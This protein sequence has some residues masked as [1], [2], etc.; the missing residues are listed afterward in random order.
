[1]DN[2]DNGQSAGE[3]HN[4][5]STSERAMSFFN[6]IQIL[7]MLSMTHTVTITGLAQCGHYI[8]ALRTHTMMYRSARS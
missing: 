5:K 8:S 2:R 7:V 4:S 3:L 6:V 1:M